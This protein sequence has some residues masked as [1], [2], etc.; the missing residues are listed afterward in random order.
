MDT[1]RERA[2]RCGSG[3]PRRKLRDINGVFVDI[4]CDSCERE[5]RSH[6]QPE[7]FCDPDHHIPDE[8]IWSEHAIRFH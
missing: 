6:Y 2:C 7:I 8:E 5:T 3:K 1:H 4:I